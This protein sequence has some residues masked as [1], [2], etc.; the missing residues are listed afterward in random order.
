MSKDKK[1][2]QPP[3]YNG[4]LLHSE[5]SPNA[6]P[7]SRPW[8]LTA[9]PLY[10]ISAHR[11][12]M[13]QPPWPS[14]TTCS[15]SVWSRFHPVYWAYLCLAGSFSSLRCQPLRG[16]PPAAARRCLPWPPSLRLHCTSLCYLLHGLYPT[17]ELLGLVCL[18]AVDCKLLEG[19]K[20]D[21]CLPAESLASSTVAVF[22]PR[23]SRHPIDTC[24]IN[25]QRNKEWAAINTYSGWKGP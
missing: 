15:S 22:R 19:R 5:S 16:P 25:R 2:E 3:P 20:L 7:Q 24:W 9:A 12:F 21:H 6:W 8:D 11:L 10:Y 18:S 17:W 13:H 1:S 4:S 23:H 14:F